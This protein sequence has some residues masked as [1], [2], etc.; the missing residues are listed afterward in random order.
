MFESEFWERSQIKNCEVARL[1]KRG[2]G[3]F[4][5]R[6]LIK[7]VHLGIGGGWGGLWGVNME[8]RVRFP[9]KVMGHYG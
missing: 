3:E 8:G 1:A 9:E 5:E 6:S 2:G 7:V 4:W